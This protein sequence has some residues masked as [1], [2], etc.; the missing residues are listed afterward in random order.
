MKQIIYTIA[1]LLPLSLTAAPPLKLELI[2]PKEKISLKK[3][4]LEEVAPLAKVSKQIEALME[5]PKLTPAIRKEMRKLQSQLSKGRNLKQGISLKLRFTNTSDK[6]F[7][8]RY[9]PDVSRNLLTVEGPA[10][11]DL[12]YMGPMTLEFR[13]P[14]PTTIKAGKS[15]DF[16]IEDLKYGARDMSRWLIGKPG[17]YTISLR[18]VG[19]IDE[20]KVE[21]KTEKATVVVE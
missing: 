11:I 14:K 10:A 17:K 6:D 12:P 4:A 16:P 20:K 13:S 18:F 5:S 19:R 3:E 8:F 2:V 15:V 1:A 7:T 21:L 9:G